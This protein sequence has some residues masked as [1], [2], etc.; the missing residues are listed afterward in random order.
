[1]E[2]HRPLGAGGPALGSPRGDRAEPAQARGDATDPAHALGV[3]APSPLGVG[4][5]DQPPASVLAVL[6]VAATEP[7]NPLGVAGKR[8][9][10]LGVFREQGPLGV[11]ATDPAS[12]LAVLG[13]A[14]TEP[15]NPLGVGG[16][17]RG[18]LGV[19]REQAPLGVG[20]TMPPSVKR[21]YCSGGLIIT[22]G[23]ITRS[24]TTILM[25][26]P[27]TSITGRWDI[28]EGVKQQEQQPH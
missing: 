7:E 19:F 17:T 4:T 8:R 21:R 14:A 15:E 22:F 16:K 11:G 24:P 3:G 13:V 20:A 12:V 28:E 25:S 9:G 26:R 23:G 6:G 10:S 5:T 27:I 18:S 1:M 2:R